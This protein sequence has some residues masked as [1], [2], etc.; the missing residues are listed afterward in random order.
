MQ[1]IENKDNTVNLISSVNSNFIDV[2]QRKFNQSC[3]ITNHTLVTD[4]ELSTVNDL[5]PQH[6]EQL[7]SLQPEIIILGSGNEHAF[8]DVILLDPVARNNIGF[9]VMNNKS[10]ARTYNVLVAEDRTVACLLII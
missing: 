7:I 6:I 10:A 3:I 5:N 8:P 9:E 2:N 4:I 1:L